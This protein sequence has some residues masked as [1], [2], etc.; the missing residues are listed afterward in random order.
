MTSYD[1]IDGFINSLSSELGND[2][3]M[4][5]SAENEKRPFLGAE[6]LATYAVF[7]LGIFASSFLE[8][9]KKE[10]ENTA[11]TAGKKLAE[12]IIAKTKSALAK[13]KKPEK[14]NE[15]EKQQA[16]RVIDDALRQAAADP[17]IGTV[18][19]AA[20]RAGRDEI[21]FELETKGMDADEAQQK[22][23]QLMQK[24]VARLRTV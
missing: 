11:K 4:L 2:T 5:L 13:L 22:A 20:E 23:E 15:N 3:M 9:L 21:A 17:E 1:D 14:L 8:S 7:L 19:Q 24:I 16:L 10:L 6:A 18:L 12:L